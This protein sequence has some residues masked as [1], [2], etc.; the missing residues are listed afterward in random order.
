MSHAAFDPDSYALDRTGAALHVLA[1]RELCRSR[2]AEGAA[3]TIEGLG[4]R[5]TVTPV[6]WYA[7]A[8]RLARAVPLLLVDTPWDQER[9]R[10]LLRRAI[11]VLFHLYTHCPLEVLAKM[12]RTDMVGPM[13]VL[14]QGYVPLR[15]LA[16][17]YTPGQ[18]WIVY[19]QACTALGGGEQ[20]ELSLAVRRANELREAGAHRA[21]HAAYRLLRGWEPDQ[22]V[23]D[24]MRRIKIYPERDTVVLPPVDANP[25]RLEDTSFM[26]RGISPETDQPGVRQQTELTHP[27]RNFEAGTNPYLL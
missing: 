18:P 16:V 23:R 15:A 21:A 10:D 6:L 1:C 20:L 25:P 8:E 22:E 13:R 14:D 12:R 7:V 17:W 2:P 5:P 19:R 9:H 26:R 3:W 24:F 4:G 27:N 11:G